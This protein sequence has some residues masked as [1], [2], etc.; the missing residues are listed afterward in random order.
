MCDVI[1]CRVAEEVNLA[2]NVDVR[3]F[4]VDHH[5]ESSCRRGQELGPVHHEVGINLEKQTRLD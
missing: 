4:Q 2:E 3:D 5:T 1:L